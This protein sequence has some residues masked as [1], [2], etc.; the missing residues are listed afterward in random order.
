MIISSVSSQVI[1]WR[2]KQ[3]HILDQRLLPGQIQIRKY[4]Q[5]VAVAEAIEKMVIRGAPAIG[6]AAAYA[7]VLAAYTARQSKLDLQQQLHLAGKQLCAARPTAINLHWAVQQMLHTAATA[8]YSDTAAT[9]ILLQQAQHIHQ[10]Q[11]QAEQAMAICAANYMADSCSGSTGYTIL[12]HCNAGAL[13][14]A[15]I[16][17]ALGVI[18]KLHLQSRLHH[19]YASETRPWLQGARLTAWE[20][21]Q[22]DIPVSVLAE[23]AAA[24]LMRTQEI[25]WL[26]VGADRITLNGDVINKIGTLNHAIVAHH[27]G[28]NVMV[29]APCSSIDW[30]VAD[31]SGVPIE[32]RSAV[33]LGGSGE[34][35]SIPSGIDVWNPVFDCTPATLVDIIITERGAVKPG[36]VST[37]AN[38]A[39]ADSM[40]AAV[41]KIG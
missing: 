39:D 2:D 28:V 10:Q 1:A 40:T 19:V 26:I 37:L 22:D 6:I 25:H 38:S 12:T 36:A 21:Q 23:A 41:T 34:Q 18:R 7:M 24:A 11:Q 8:T 3:L 31:G 13:A 5:A 4:T 32:H 27:H 14:T 15:G 33:E 20:L 17:T 35:C 16:G 29:V 30:E 9:E